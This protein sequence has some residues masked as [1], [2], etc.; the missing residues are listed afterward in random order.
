MRKLSRID[1]R[2]GASAV[3]LADL[4]IPRLRL[5]SINIT[6]NMETPT[7]PI[8]DEHLDPGVR[9][10]SRQNRLEEHLI[11]VKRLEKKIL[12]ET[13]QRIITKER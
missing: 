5:P 1:T 10:R 4:Y 13:G 9:L 8:F 11:E 12:N 3:P 6:K 2:F 7:P